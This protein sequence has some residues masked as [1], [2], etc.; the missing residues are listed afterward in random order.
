MRRATCGC[1]LCF[2]VLSYLGAIFSEKSVIDADPRVEMF[3]ELDSG[4]DGVCIRPFDI[5]CICV[6]VA[7]DLRHVAITRWNGYWAL[8]QVGYGLGW[9]LRM[10]YGQGGCRD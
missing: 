8:V 7:F 4:H 3:L 2:C 9:V 5:H 1:I 6:C 10:G